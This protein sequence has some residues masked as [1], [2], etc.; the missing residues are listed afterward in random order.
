MSLLIADFSYQAKTELNQTEFLTR[1]QKFANELEVPL[2][3]TFVSVVY[4]QANPNLVASTGTADPTETAAAASILSYPFSQEPLPLTALLAGWAQLPTMPL[5]YSVGASSNFNRVGEALLELAGLSYDSEKGWRDRG[6]VVL[7]PPQDSALSLFL[8]HAI[9]HYLQSG[10]FSSNLYICS[11][12]TNTP[13]LPPTLNAS[14]NATSPLCAE[15][16]GIASAST[17]SNNSSTSSTNSTSN[18]TFPLYL[19]A[20]YTDVTTAS[21]WEKMATAPMTTNSSAM[22]QW[23]LQEWD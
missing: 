18:L 9:S 5:T 1:C 15:P 3:E 8:G 10:C 20:N 21:E 23:H 19:Q 17:D 13:A 7:I 12:L 22:R 4:L 14:N 6:M 16:V 11:P 2:A